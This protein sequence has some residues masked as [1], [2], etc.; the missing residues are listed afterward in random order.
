MAEAEAVVATTLAPEAEAE[1][2]MASPPPLLRLDKGDSGA[3][4]AAVM[5]SAA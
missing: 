1:V 3:G 4:A 5:E 2:I